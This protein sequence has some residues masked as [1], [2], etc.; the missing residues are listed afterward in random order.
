MLPKPDH[1]E[2]SYKGCDTLAGKKAIITGAELQKR[3]DETSRPARRTCDRL[4]DARR[5]DVKL[6]FGRDD[7]RT[8]GK[9][10]L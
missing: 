4:R 9:P 3:D 10:L 7:C 1:G 8:G 6:C 5:S 2:K